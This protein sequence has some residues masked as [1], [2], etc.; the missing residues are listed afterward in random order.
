MKSELRTAS[1]GSQYTVD[2]AYD[3][4][5]ISIVRASYFRP[6][7]KFTFCGEWVVYAETVTYN[8]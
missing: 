2:Y 7:Q 4:N 5:W 1:Q 6:Y 3:I 8:G